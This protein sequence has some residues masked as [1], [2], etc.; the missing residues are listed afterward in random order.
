MSW[1]VANSLDILLAEVNDAAP[2]R[3]KVADGSIGDTAHSSRV[4]DHNPNPAGVVRARDFTHDPAGG[5]DAYDFA[6]RVRELGRSGHPA[7][8]A[9]AYVI[10]CG[11]IASAT[12]GWAWRP[13]TG[14]NPHDH[15]THV[16]VATAAAGYDSTRPWGVMGEPDMKPEDFDKI[17]RIVEKAVDDAL[18]QRLGNGRTLLTNLTL[19]AEK[20]GVKPKPDSPRDKK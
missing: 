1:R 10:S 15:H 16:S 9:G 6:E 19:V 11:E 3:S 20:V 5:F 18:T 13:Y 2:N 14:S 12:Y 4:S 17:Q 7:L 8:G